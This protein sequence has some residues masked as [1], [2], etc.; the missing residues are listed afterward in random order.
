MLLVQCCPCGITSNTFTIF[1]LAHFVPFDVNGNFSQFNSLTDVFRDSA[2]Y[3][4]VSVVLCCVVKSAWFLRQLFHSKKWVSLPVFRT[5]IR[6]L[7]ILIV[8]I[9]RNS[10]RFIYSIIRIYLFISK[11]YCCNYQTL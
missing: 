6:L 5:L 2:N 4:H 9:D 11:I 7:N 1:G 3:G 8:H 10:E